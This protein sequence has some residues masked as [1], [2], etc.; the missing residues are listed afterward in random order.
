MLHAQKAVGLMQFESVSLMNATFVSCKAFLVFL[1]R[2]LLGFF[3]SKWRW[4]VMEG[5]GQ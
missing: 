3:G 5:N 1:A 2:N 4:S